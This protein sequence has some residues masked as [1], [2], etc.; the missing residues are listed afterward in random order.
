MNVSAAGRRTPSIPVIGTHRIFANCFVILF[1]RES[2][3]GGRRTDVLSGF[4]SDN[5]LRC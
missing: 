4:I 1:I 3:T 2:V 5:G